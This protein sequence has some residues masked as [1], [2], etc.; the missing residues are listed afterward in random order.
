MN[1]FDRRQKLLA[2]TLPLLY[3]L[4]LVTGALLQDYGYITYVARKLGLEREPTFK[5]ATIPGFLL[6]D[7]FALTLGKQDLSTAICRPQGWPYVRRG[8]YDLFPG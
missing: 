2:L 5:S 1:R 4:G 6:E 8:G 3:I 7:A